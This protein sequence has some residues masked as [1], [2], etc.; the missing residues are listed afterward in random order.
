MLIYVAL[1]LILMITFGFGF[2][3]LSSREH[4]N[5]VG[6]GLQMIGT[7]ALIPMV[8]G[9][10]KFR[11]L[12]LGEF[13]QKQIAQVEPALTPETY[14]DYY[15]ARNLPISMGNI[16]ASLGL[17]WLLASFIIQPGEGYA[18]LQWLVRGVLSLFGFTWLNLFML[19]HI[20]RQVSVT[21][22]DWLMATFIT[23]DFPMAFLGIAFAGMAYIVIY[24]LL[25]ALRFLFGKDLRRVLLL[26]TLPFFALGTLLELLATWM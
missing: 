18:F 7:L 1:I 17:M 20:Y 19:L 8:I 6:I 11:N 4:V 26:V 9:K 16:L 2:S 23:V 22:P 25:G 24:W 12:R 21:I 5:R 15:L 10:E 13:H 14:F 3:I